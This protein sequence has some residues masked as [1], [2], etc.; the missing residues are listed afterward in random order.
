M[1]GYVLRRSIP[2]IVG[3]SALLVAVAFLAVVF[4][5]APLWFPAVFA[6]V[7]IG[8]QYAINPRIIEWLVPADVVP[9]TEQ[10]YVGSHPLL[11][12]VTRR[13]AQ[14][15]VPLVKLGI[16]DDGTPNAFTFGHTRKDARIWVTRGLL[17]R[18]DERELDAV[19][20]HEIG[21]VRNLDFVVM[22]VAAV[23]PM[24][25]YLCFVMTR[26]QRGHA[27]IV[28]IAAYAGYLLSQLTLLS[29]SRA[30]EYGADHWSCV[31]TVDGDALAS[32]LVKVAYGIG[33]VEVELKNQAE[34]LSA[35]GRE[36]KRQAARLK[37]HTSRVHAMRAMGIFEPRQAEAV[38]VAFANGADAEHAMA[39]LRWDVINPW[40]RTLEKLSSHPLVAR[41]IDAL[42]RSGLPGAPKHADVGRVLHEVDP[43]ARAFVR[44]RYLVELFVGVA[45]WVVL[46]SVLGFGVLD[47]SAEA[48]G[49]A[50]VSAGALLLVK[51]ALRYPTAYEPA[52]IADLLHRLD[53]SPVRGIPVEISGRVVGRGF[54]G[55]VLS[56]DLVVQDETGFLPLLYQQPFP[57]AR[58]LFGVSKAR[59]YLGRDVVARG[60]YRRGPGPV[61]E[62]RD[63]RSGDLAPVRVWM[64]LA[65]MAGSGLVAVAGLIVVAASVH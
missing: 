50:L 5:G 43:G 8:V 42:A 39:A 34:A 9:M 36:G 52:R 17:E 12:I 54:P 62:L 55:Y 46:I 16:V 30:R 49:L 6:I 64:W 18:L 41:R 21:H 56:P 28:A 13:C 25:L 40:G 29:L 1:A 53:A 7:M 24:V 3:L 65:R 33:Q 26:R 60:W 38:A 37:N 59:G 58:A 11:D 61:V 51:Q 44:D 47:R 57:F 2:S 23:V 27:A 15:G 32:A 19:L 31:A 14:A 22:T 63:L 48:I 20:S 10:G 4:A 45:P 35:H